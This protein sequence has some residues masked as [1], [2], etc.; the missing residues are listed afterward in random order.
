[1]LRLSS[2]EGVLPPLYIG[3]NSFPV[4]LS[5]G[6]P[7]LPIYGKLSLTNSYA[8]LTFL[9]LRP[10]SNQGAK[11]MMTQRGQELPCV[12]QSDIPQRHLRGKINENL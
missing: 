10:I 3:G 6:C 8:A 4:A 2:N 1:M 5:L 9:P 11:M 7:G 12:V